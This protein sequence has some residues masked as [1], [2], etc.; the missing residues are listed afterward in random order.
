[1]AALAAL[2]VN[3]A[4]GSL[5]WAKAELRICLAKFHIAGWERQ[6][7][8]AKQAEHDARCSNHQSTIL[9]LWFRPHHHSEVK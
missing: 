8:R 4:S 1:M 5:V 7:D 3:V 2:I 9:R 6:G